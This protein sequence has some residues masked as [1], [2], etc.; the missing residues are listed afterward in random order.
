[1]KKLLVALAVMALCAT[2]ASANHLGLYGSYW[3]TK[4]AGKGWGAGGKFRI[5]L[6]EEFLAVE[7]R[8]GYFFDLADDEEDVDGK[9]TVIPVEA[10]LVITF[11]FAEEFVA[12]AGGG[13]GY[14]FM[15][16]EVTVAGIKEDLD[17]KDEPGFFGVAG[18][19]INFSE[20]AALF[21]E[22]K[23]Q[24]LKIKEI[25]DIEVDE[26]NKLD[27]FGGNAGLLLKW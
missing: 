9:L 4:D 10:A 18:G 19:E 21:I 17:I 15:D 16:G 23:Y 12:Y 24:F 6:V 22:G 13:G 1:M 8:G 3:K 2:V 7:L 25:N 20:N 11:P 26:D 27:G 5:G 14:Y